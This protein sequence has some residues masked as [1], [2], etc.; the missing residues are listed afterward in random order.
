MLDGID[1]T[2]STDE[3]IIKQHSENKVTITLE[4]VTSILMALPQ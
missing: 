2:E 1:L 3:A 4:M